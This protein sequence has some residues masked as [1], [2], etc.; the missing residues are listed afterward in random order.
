MKDE[1][2]L[3]LKHRYPKLFRARGLR[4]LV[5]YDEAPETAELV[6]DFGPIDE[7]GIECG[8]GWFALVNR[9]S[10]ACEQEIDAM[11]AAGVAV[12]YWPRASQIKE[13]FGTLRFRVFGR[14]SEALRADILD[15][16]VVESAQIP[17][18]G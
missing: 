5:T 1:L 10:A 3:E 16:E 17:E 14:L 4:Y 2:Q 18:Q 8:D 12:E 11:A 15:A 9:L 13:K 7:R 6:S